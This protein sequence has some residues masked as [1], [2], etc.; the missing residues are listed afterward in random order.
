MNAST[1]RKAKDVAMNNGH[2]FHLVAILKRGKHIVRYGTNSSKTH[3]RFGRVYSAGPREVHSLHAEMDVLRFAKPGDDLIVL[4]YKANG[5]LSMAKPCSECQ[6]HIKEAGI[7]RVHY[8]DW[9]GDV[10]KM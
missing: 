2:V 7:R 9:S 4:R 1:L 6:R 5:N 3:P 8:S 10:V